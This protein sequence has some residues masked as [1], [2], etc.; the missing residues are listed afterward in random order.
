MLAVNKYG[1][2][3]VVDKDI[4]GEKLVHGVIFMDELYRLYCRTIADLDVP[5]NKDIVI[6]KMIHFSLK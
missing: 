6:D 2:L 4:W 3:V 5:M 1:D